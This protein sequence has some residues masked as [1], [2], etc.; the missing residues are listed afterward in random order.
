MVAKAYFL[1]IVPVVQVLRCTL[2]GVVGASLLDLSDNFDLT[3]FL[4]VLGRVVRAVIQLVGVINVN[5]VRSVG[6]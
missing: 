1:E 3:P 6:S 5:M 4:R 2:S